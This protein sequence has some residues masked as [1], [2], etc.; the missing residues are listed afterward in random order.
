MSS[1][2]ESQVRAIGI[3]A[4]TRVIGSD[5]DEVQVLPGVDENGK[6]AYFFTFYF[7]DR[8]LWN[9]AV[10][11]STEV[12]IAILDEL[13]ERATRLFLSSACCPTD[14][15]VC[16]TVLHPAEWRGR[17]RL[18][19][20]WGRR[21]MPSYVVPCPRRIARSFTLPEVRWQA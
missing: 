20:A 13:S 17:W 12:A 14:L 10:K 16:Q 2:S 1:L 8:G 3:A 19:P 18:P 9:T 21:P 7:D 5:A 6:D 4:A 15:L 11:L